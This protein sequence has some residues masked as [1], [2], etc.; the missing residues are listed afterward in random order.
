MI[1]TAGTLAIALLC[2]AAGNVL[3]RKGMGE[4]GGLA[5]WRWE[6]LAGF[7]A[8]ALTNPRVLLGFVLEGAYFALWLAVLSWA[9]VSWALPLHAAEYALAG[10]LA[11]GVLGE[12]VGP[13]RWAGIACII[14]GVAL[15]ARS[16]EEGGP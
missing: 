15:L 14:A 9:E 5:S 11:W 16:W 13:L 12:K 2:A 1:R 4:V 3:F 6:S 8:A 10:V 7:F